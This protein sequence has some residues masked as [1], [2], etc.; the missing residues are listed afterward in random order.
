MISVLSNVI[1]VPP[2]IISYRQIYIYSSGA[3]DIEAIRG[4][5]KIKALFQDPAMRVPLYI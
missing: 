4:F 5:P 1:G 3:L 2:C